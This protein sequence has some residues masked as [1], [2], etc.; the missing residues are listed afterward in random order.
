MNTPRYIFGPVPSRRFGQSLGVDLIPFKTCSLDCV[1]C[2]LGRTTIKTVSRRNFTPTGDVIAEIEGWLRAGNTADYITLS[3]SGEPTLH[4]GFG[5]VLRFLKRTSIPSLLLTNGTMLD[6]P[7]VRKAAI[8]ADVVK[9]S[10]SAWDPDSFIRVNRPHPDLSFDRLIQGLMAFRS[11]FSGRLQM[12]VFLMTGL[13][14]IPGDVGKIAAWAEKIKPDQIQLNTVVRPPA[15]EYAAPVTAERLE[16]LRLLFDPPAEHIDD[17]KTTRLA[18]SRVDI[19]GIL[20]VLQRRPCTI[21]QLTREFG[22]HINE[23]SK[24]LCDL[25]RTHHVRTHY[26]NTRLYYTVRASAPEIGG[27]H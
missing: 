24:H 5:E 3:G 23:V 2:H 15:E 6:C 8:H 19:E 1:F 12:E 21:E 20:G 27:T 10:L 26:I 17:S 14:S 13:N 22:M 25:M 16:S 18:G 11:E 4:E 9:I 7:E